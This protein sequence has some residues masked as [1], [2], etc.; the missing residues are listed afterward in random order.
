MEGLQERI[1]FYMER[2]GY[3]YDEAYR[4]ALMDLEENK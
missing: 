3:D 2:F 4:E 1:S